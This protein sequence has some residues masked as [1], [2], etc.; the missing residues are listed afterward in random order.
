MLHS[1]THAPALVMLAVAQRDT[2]L[3]SF[4]HLHTQKLAT[5]DNVPC[6]RLSCASTVM[7]LKICETS[8]GPVVVVGCLES[9]Q[10]VLGAHLPARALGV[11]CRAS[12][13]LL[14]FPPTC[15][16]LLSLPALSCFP[17]F[18]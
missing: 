15:V 2:S 11:S 18:L 16:H 6:K 17:P 1:F 14:F 3:P 12:L 10:V 13:L 9:I 5:E 4:C 8:E 7:S